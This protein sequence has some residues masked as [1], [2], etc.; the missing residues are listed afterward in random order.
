MLLRVGETNTIKDVWLGGLVIVWSYPLATL[1]PSFVIGA[2]GEVPTYLID[3]RRLM[4]LILSLV[5]AYLAYYLYLA[6][7]EG[8]VRK[9]RRGEQRRGLGGIFD[10]LAGASSFVPGV[11]AAAFIVV[12]VTSAAT[13]L[14][15]V[16]GVWLYTRWSL[17]T[18]VIR[19]DGVG[20]LAAM[21]RSRELVRGKFWF[22]F[23]T[24]SVAYYLEG[25][26]IDL[27]AWTAGLMTG[28]HTWG[29]WVG[30]AI[31]A[32]VVTPVAAFATSLAHSGRRQTCLTCGGRR[33]HASRRPE[34]F[35]GLWSHLQ[36][37]RYSTVRNV[38]NGERRKRAQSSGSGRDERADRE[39]AVF[40]LPVPVDGGVLRV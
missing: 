11:T 15:V 40:G 33:G 25:V 31:L 36:E 30:G 35:C 27:G 12:T 28:S 29:E 16:P 1:V 7:A 24:A 21:R 5:T 26:M 39:R 6:Y 3:D 18:P 23:A 9:V 13:L 2:I 14:L 17:T 10:D 38:A 32:T 37:P 4:D 8:I 22:V 34:E 20:P 19:E